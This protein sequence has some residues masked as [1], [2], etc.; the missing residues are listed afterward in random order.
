ML[1][2]DCGGSGGRAGGR[3][4]GGNVQKCQRKTHIVEKVSWT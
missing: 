1:V 3:G 4:G 2:F